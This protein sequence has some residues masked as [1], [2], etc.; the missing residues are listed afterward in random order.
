MSVTELLPKQQPGC[1]QVR[2]ATS[3]CLTQSDRDI[4]A[5]AI[6]HY[7]RVPLPFHYR[8]EDIEAVRLTATTATIVTNDGV[9]YLPIADYR[10]V[11]AMTIDVRSRCIPDEDD[12]IFAASILQ[13][14]GDSVSSDDIDDLL[15]QDGTLFVVSGHQLIPISLDDIPDSPFDVLAA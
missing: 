10:S 3:R 12:R 15:F 2:V 13:R 5:S 7:F 14:Q 8:A 4:A 11:E 6:N 1:W 9:L